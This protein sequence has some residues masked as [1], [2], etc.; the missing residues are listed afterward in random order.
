MNLE[1]I[2]ISEITEAAE[3]TEKNE[4]GY[5]GGQHI[6]EKG[7]SVSSLSEIHASSYS[8]PRA[9]PRIFYVAVN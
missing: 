5:H 4:T 2:Q 8:S 3:E 7:S 1:N 6:D 9:L